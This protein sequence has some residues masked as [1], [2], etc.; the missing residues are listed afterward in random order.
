MISVNKN[1]SYKWAIVT[2]MFLWA[3]CY[4]L[5]VLGLDNAPHITFAAL[6]ALLA[7]L[8]LLIIAII[9]G[10]PQP[11]KL[12]QWLYIAG[13]GIGATSI[14]FYGMFHASE[15]VSPGL[16]TVLTSLQPML[17]AV[18]AFLFIKESMQ[19][20]ETIAIILG[21]IGMLI[22]ATNQNTDSSSINPLGL[23]YL[24]LTIVGLSISNILIKKITGKVDALVAMGWQLIFGA[25]VLWV[26]A[27]T[28][29]N[30]TEINWN[31]HFIISLLGLS[32]FGTA[33]AYWLWFKVLENVDL[34]YANSFSFLVPALGILMGLTFFKEVFDVQK[35][36]GV[37]LIF[38][39]IVIIYLPIRR[40]PHDI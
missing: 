18:L 12:I 15:F 37:A 32:I 26:I 4:P 20:N 25:L 35:A 11:K 19:T 31:K 8:T 16:A 5:I 13:I 22:I 33:L 38:I 14:G 10:R 17:T 30:P 21:F 2:V 39:G 7:G 36:I 1:K 40:K 6:R 23:T 34:V 24:I 3:I 28:T 29:E 9:L 27:L